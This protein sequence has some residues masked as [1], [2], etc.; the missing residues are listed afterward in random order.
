MGLLYLIRVGEP[1]SRP[2]NENLLETF[3]SNLLYWKDHTEFVFI[4]SMAVLLIY[5][6]HPRLSKNLLAKKLHYY[7]SYLDGLFY[8]HPNGAYFLPKL[9]GIKT[10]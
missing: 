1:T 7:F 9:T 10:C 5:H 3:D 2:S 6:F 4:I 8:S